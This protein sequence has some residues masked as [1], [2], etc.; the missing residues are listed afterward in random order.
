VRHTANLALLLLIVL[1]PPGC[2][3][4][5]SGDADLDTDADTDS[6]SDTT[7]TPGGL[8]LTL[9][10]SFTREDVG[11]P[12]GEDEIADFTRKVTG[13]WKQVDLFTWVYEISHGMDA[14]TGY[15]DYLVWWHDVEAVKQ[16][17]TV[18]F[19]NKEDGGGHNT[20][21]PG[22]TLLSQA[23]GG[24]LASGDEA[25]GRIVEQFAKGIT[26]TMKGFVYHEHDLLE[27]LMARN[28]VASNH[29]FTLPSGKNKAVD[30]TGWY[31]EYET[32]NTARYNFPNNPTWGDVWVTTMRSKDDLPNI[33]R[34]TGWFP[35]VIELA[36]DE[37]VRDAVEEAY[38]LMQAFAQDIVD[39]GYH[40]RSKDAQGQPFIPEQDLA[41]LVDYTV[42][43]PLAECD[44][45]LVSA[46]LGYGEPLDND[47]ED[48]RSL[49][50][51]AAGA[52]NYYN[53]DIVNFFHLDAIQMTLLL[54][55][56]DM[57]RALL[58]GMVDRLERYQ[59]PR[60]PEPGADN[61]HWDKDVALLT[62]RSASMGVP[63]TSEEARRLHHYYGHSV[64]VHSTFERWDMW[65]A[66][67]PDGTY[68]FRTGYQPR[69]SAEVLRVEDIAF[70]LEY[71]WS[72]FWNP[73]GARFVDCEVVRDPSRWGE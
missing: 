13:F 36:P 4:G 31:S 39:S 35:Y 64:D 6:D 42:L 46:L 16:G 63:L 26:A 18:T 34:A 19:R 25:M 50:D 60:R 24:Y 52:S 10:F 29:S 51:S 11:E 15:P 5:G 47:C 58:Q 21:E 38:A 8:P 1:A 68:D 40:I 30:Y 53:Y 67:V 17:D 41:S 9:P 12:L 72:P 14:S 48:G 37:Y 71:C 62:L 49:Y 7:H 43:D 28:I 55:H 22:A 56:N 45:R 27:H 32:W 57:A 33:Y 59:D 20:V 73:D 44:P 54:E 65:D 70:L 69:G 23:I 2:G 61:E 66:S 3:E